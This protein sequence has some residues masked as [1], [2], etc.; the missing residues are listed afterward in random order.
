M[1]KEN[2]EQFMKQVAES[3]KL[4]TRIGR[5][6]AGDALITLG[7]EHGCEFTA[8]DLQESAEL[9]DDELDGVAGGLHQ[10]PYSTGS[11][12]VKVAV[13]DFIIVKEIDEVSPP[14]LITAHS[15]RKGKRRQ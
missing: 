4:Q 2:L 15:G 3:D 14:R 10:I 5:E 12:A 6:I 7:A 8:E 9:S 11:G 13:H 1:S